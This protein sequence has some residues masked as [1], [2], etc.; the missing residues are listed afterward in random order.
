MNE[1]V[2]KHLYKTQMCR[3]NLWHWLCF[4]HSYAAFSFLFFVMCINNISRL[5]MSSFNLI[6]WFDIGILGSSKRFKRHNR[7]NCFLCGML[8]H[9]NL[10]IESNQIFR[11]S[12]ISYIVYNT[13]FFLRMKNSFLYFVGFG[14]ALLCF[15]YF[16]CFW[17]DQ[18][19]IQNS[20]CNFSLSVVCILYSVWWTDVETKTNATHCISP[21]TILN[22]LFE[23]TTHT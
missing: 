2:H 16:W 20:E 5:K 4:A 1:Y 8:N 19:F 21:H 14:C 3:F 17:S 9:A 18:K 23:Y 15:W 13:I 10:N 12:R 22:F 11:M 6:W 7:V